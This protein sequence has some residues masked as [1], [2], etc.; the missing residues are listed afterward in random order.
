[1]TG[2]LI[3]VAVVLIGWFAAGS[4][5]N[6]RK[7]HAALKWL[8]GGLPA[9]GERT[10]VRWL[11]TTAIEMLVAKA[12]PP[13]AEVAVIVF[14]QPRDMPWLWA[15]SRQRGRRDTL[16]FRAGL[17]RA[18][19]VELEVLDPPSWSGREGLRRMAGQRWSSREPSGAGG[20][21]TYYKFASALE[22]ADAL[23]AA[24]RDGGLALR[25]L[26][27]HPSGT[28]LEVHADLPG[29]APATEFFSTL[30]AIG[31]RAGGS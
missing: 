10:T 9:V 20:L 12:K 7:G 13:F 25:R 3:V 23:I 30:Q 29:P 11:G 2:A 15:L 5:A 28:H 21:V 22:T 19:A 4:I 27:L 8:E 14:L 1:M 26:A 16:I 24:A 17:R 18:P 6:V 31:E